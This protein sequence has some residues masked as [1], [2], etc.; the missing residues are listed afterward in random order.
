MQTFKQALK[1]RKNDKGTL[2]QKLT[3]F[4]MYHN[5][6]YATTG[7]APVELL[8]KRKIRTHLDLM[9]P[10]VGD[11]VAAKQLE[12]KRDHDRHSRKSEFCV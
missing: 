5:I 1:A 3:R 10:S 4:L 12:Q 8:L 2:M 11:H 6:P 7:V 9:T